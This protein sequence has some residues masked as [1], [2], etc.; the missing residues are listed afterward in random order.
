VADGAFFLFGRQADTF[1]E[2]PVGEALEL[3]E[4]QHAN[5]KKTIADLNISE[6]TAPRPFRL[7]SFLTASAGLQSSITSRTSETQARSTLRASTILASSN[8]SAVF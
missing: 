8:A 2:Y 7:S 4:V 3:L 6:S 1:V 5:V